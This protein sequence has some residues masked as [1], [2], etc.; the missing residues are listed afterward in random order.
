MSPSARRVLFPA[1]LAFAAA[2]AALADDWPQWRGPERNG[3]SREKGALGAWPPKKLWSASVGQ[4]YSSVVVALGRVFVTGHAR[5][6]GD[7]GIDSVYCLDAATGKE[8]WVHR[9]ECSSSRK[10][11]TA[12]YTGPR[13]TP[14]VSGG[15]V[16]TI[17]IDGHLFCLDVS[18]GKVKWF[19]KLSK[20][21]VEDGEMLYGFCASPAISG[22]KLLCY[23]NGACMAFDAAD[24]KPLW[25]R[26]GGKPIWNGASPVIVEFGG[27]PCV[28][29]G[30]EELVGV[31]VESGTKLWDYPLGRT[32]VATPVVSGDALFFSTYPNK[33]VCGVVRAAEGKAQPVWSNRQMQNYH[34]GAPC[35]WD[36]HLYGV[37][38]A[39]TEFIYSDDKVSALKCVDFA[40]GELRWTEKGM[41][42]AQVVAADG[43]L[44]IQRECGELVLA[45]ASREGY[46]ELGRAK[47]LDGPAW[48]V[49]ALSGGRVYCRSNAGEVVC[50]LTGPE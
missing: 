26:K 25:R 41:G 36:G 12:E 33:G 19:Q 28:V 48:A 23:L 5:G 21:A 9:Y 49:P 39:R 14:L 37:D 6:E 7:K 47:A 42:W 1:A 24:G 34:V 30:E 10:D 43:R 8:L 38:C 29:F 40:T 3:S 44:L 18:S 31:D 35:L 45:E 4:G 13:S 20:F 46:K 15:S 2:V 11:K 17:S 22:G 27:K 50:L 32:A 16:F